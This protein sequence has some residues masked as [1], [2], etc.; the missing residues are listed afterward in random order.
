MF[1]ISMKETLLTYILRRLITVICFDPTNIY[2]YNY[3]M[4]ILYKLDTIQFELDGLNTMPLSCSN[5]LNR[6]PGCPRIDGFLRVGIVTPFL[7][8]HMDPMRFVK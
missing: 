3:I 7:F 6:L 8:S 5:L 1:L 2:I 4:F